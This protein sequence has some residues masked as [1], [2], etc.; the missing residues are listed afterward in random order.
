[1]LSLA[2]K[3]ITTLGISDRSVVNVLTAIGKAILGA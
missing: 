3:T 1:M 2:N